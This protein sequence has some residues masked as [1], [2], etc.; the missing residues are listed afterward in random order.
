MD[1]ILLVNDIPDH[2]MV[3]ERALVNSGFR[4]VMAATAADALAKA[5]VTPPDCA[6][7]DVR[8][9][10]MR[11]WDL[12]KELKAGPAANIPI[13]LLAPDISR[14]SAIDSVN[15][16]C[17]AWLAYP[18]IADDLVRAVRQ[19]LALGEAE[20][21]SADEAVLGVRTCPACAGS[22]VRPTLRMRLIQYFCCRECGFCWRVDSQPA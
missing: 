21:A 6:I 14:Q 4:V 1:L 13:V 10:D 20:P 3:Y 12:C 17:N 2:A 19:V 22:L 11:G 5:A 18:T 15:V 16:G 7:I 9:P 8:L